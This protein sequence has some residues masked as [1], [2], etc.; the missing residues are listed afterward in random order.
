MASTECPDSQLACGHEL[1]EEPGDRGGGKQRL[2]RLARLGA[3]AHG[4]LVCAFDGPRNDLV[5]GGSWE[6]LE[7]IEPV[8]VHGDELISFHHRDTTTFVNVM[9]FIGSGDLVLMSHEITT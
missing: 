3:R 9:R 1:G 5:A 4:D 7:S 6:G 8:L 2:R